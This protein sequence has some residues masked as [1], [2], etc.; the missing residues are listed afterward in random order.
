MSLDQQIANGGGKAVLKT[1]QGEALTVQGSGKKLMVT[2][3]KGGT[4]HVTIVDVDQ[5]NGVIQVVDRVL[6]PN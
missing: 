2:D 6:L 3:E 5:N 4:A 1:M